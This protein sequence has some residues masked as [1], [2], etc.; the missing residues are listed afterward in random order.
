MKI[1]KHLVAATLAV[2]LVGSTG[3]TVPVGDSMNAQIGYTV[4][5]YALNNSGLAQAGSQGGGGALGGLFG[6][7]VG[8]KIGKRAA[9][10]IGAR[11]GAAVGA[12]AGPAGAVVGAV[13]GA[14]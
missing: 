13:V 5:Y 4:A 14:M 8:N 11:V 9:T 3:A 1:K 2:G 7:Y 6:M 10:L 12:A